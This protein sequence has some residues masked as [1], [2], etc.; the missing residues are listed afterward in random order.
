MHHGRWRGGATHLHSGHHDP[1]FAFQLLSRCSGPAWASLCPLHS[2]PLHS[3]EP[4][5]KPLP[6]QSCHLSEVPQSFLEPSTSPLPMG[7]RHHRCVQ[8]VALSP[9]LGLQQFSGCDQHSGNRAD[10]GR[11]HPGGPR[12]SHSKT[13]VLGCES[14]CDPRLPIPAGDSPRVC[15]RSAQARRWVHQRSA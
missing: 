10:T 4:Q 13:Q 12:Q 6:H 7:Q 15:G 2:W 8:T 9:P 11:A 5:P 1:V 14:G 3:A